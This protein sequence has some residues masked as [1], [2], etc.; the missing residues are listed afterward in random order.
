[1]KVIEQVTPVW[2]Q[3]AYALHFKPAL[4]KAIDRNNPCKCELAC[5][6]MFARWLDGMARQPVSWETLIVALRD[7][8]EHD[9]EKLGTVLDMF[10]R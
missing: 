1:M 6:D 2:E 10:F 8:G 9:L 3:L 4:V 5:I 7:S